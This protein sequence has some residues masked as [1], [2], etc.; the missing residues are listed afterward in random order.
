MSIKSIVNNLVIKYGT[1]CPFELAKHL[2]VEVIFEPLGKSWG[3]YSKH[4]RIPIIH[5]NQDL[6]EGSQIFTCAHELGHV[7]QHPDTDTSFL[8]MHTLFSADK[9]EIEANTF[10][11]ELLLPDELFF[12][13]GDSSYTIWYAIEANGVPLELVSL[14]TLDGNIFIK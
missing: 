13:Q 14:K 3:Y 9:I 6:S 7:I 1:N 5:I 11:I 8:K 10:A 4:F 2:G 12:E